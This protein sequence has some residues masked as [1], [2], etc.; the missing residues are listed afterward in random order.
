MTVS[1]PRAAPTEDGVNT[2]SPRPCCEYDGGGGGGGT[3]EYDAPLVAADA[4]DEAG[5]EEKEA[6]ETELLVGAFGQGDVP[7]MMIDLP[8]SFAS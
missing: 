1:P 4:E 7:V 8:S 3:F 2:I 5:E 6:D